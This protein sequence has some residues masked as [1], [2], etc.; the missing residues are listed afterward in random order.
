[1]P[2]EHAEQC[3]GHIIRDVEG[4]YNQHDY[5]REKKLAYEELAA[6]IERMVNPQPNVIPL[7]GR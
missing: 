7:T 4:T 6:L 5:Y 1:M 3:L 2:G